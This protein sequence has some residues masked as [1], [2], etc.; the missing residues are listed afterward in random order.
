MSQVK[1]KI[2]KKTPAKKK[3]MKIMKA[4]SKAIITKADRDAK[5]NQVLAAI[6]VGI[7]NKPGALVSPTATKVELT[8][9]EWKKL[10]KAISTITSTVKKL[11]DTHEAESVYMATLE[12]MQYLMGEVEDLGDEFDLSGAN[13]K[14]IVLEIIDAIVEVYP[15][16]FKLVGIPLPTF[17]VKGFIK[18][19]VRNIASYI[20]DFIIKIYNTSKLKLGKKTK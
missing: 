20:I 14:R 19:A 15:T 16:K 2:A 6:E 12:V 9:A 7:L 17:L 5:T 8:N 13:K 10:E 3:A 4:T 1:K 18:K 11:W